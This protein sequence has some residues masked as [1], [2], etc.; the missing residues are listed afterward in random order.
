VDGWDGFDTIKKQHR[1]KERK[2]RKRSGLESGGD[3]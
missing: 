3:D 2:K 1:K